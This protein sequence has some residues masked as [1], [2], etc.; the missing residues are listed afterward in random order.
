MTMW[1]I[2]DGINSLGDGLIEPNSAMVTMTNRIYITILKLIFISLSLRGAARSCDS[3]W[4]Y[5]Y[6]IT[7]RCKKKTMSP[8]R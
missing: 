2:Q 5:Q 1:K 6:S 7:F 3:D 4:F 8:N